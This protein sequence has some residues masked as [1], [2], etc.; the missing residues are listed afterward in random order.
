MVVENLAQ[1]K[2]P[3]VTVLEPKDGAVVTTDRVPVRLLLADPNG[4]R[5]VRVHV[6]VNLCSGRNLD[7]DPRPGAEW[8]EEV[9]L[10]PDAENRIT[11]IAVND[12]GVE[13]KP[14]YI[15]VI[16]RSPVKRRPNLY[17]LSI[18]VSKYNS[19]DVNSL[20][21]ADKDARDIAAAYQK[22][23][24]L[25][26]EKVDAR[27]LTDPNAT[28]ER[29]QEELKAFCSQPVQMDD[30]A[31]VFLAG[32]GGPMDPKSNNRTYCFLPCDAVKGRLE[33]TGTPGEEI[34]ETLR[35]L[36]CNVILVFDTCR[37]G[38]RIVY[39]DDP[40]LQMQFL[41]GKVKYGRVT[42]FSCQPNERSQE[43]EE[44]GN[45]AFTRK[46][47]EGIQGAADS[48]PSGDGM[49]SLAELDEYLRKA[50]PAITN[51]DQNPR[52][53]IPYYVPLV[54]DKFPVARTRPAR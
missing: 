53:E 35:G 14:E 43:K 4:R 17:L 51:P 19:R 42:F 49:V 46:F 30:Y 36:S 44:W 13:S 2:P 21:F 27:A 25:L 48:G 31:I 32:H 45:G 52:M 28:K 33:E 54:P 18:G 9:R 5:I 10:Q 20:Q 41:T 24:G 50:V 3:Q 39:A 6:S 11:V 22:Q 26:F 8:T 15:R 29:I 7:F 34:L 16:C 40:E 38:S 23:E 47:I 1:F 12:A 37:E